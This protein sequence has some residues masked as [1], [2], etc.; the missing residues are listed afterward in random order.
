MK[1]DQDQRIVMTLDAGGTNFVFSAMQAC[2][3]IVEPITLPSHANDLP[4]C[5]KT[6]V[7]GFTQVRD[8][9][10]EKPVAI[11]FAFPGPADYASGI[12]GD[13]GNLPGL[14]RRR[15]PGA[16]AGG[17]VRPAGLSE[18]RRRPVRL[19]RGHCRLASLCER[20]AR[21]R[22]GSPKRYQN[23]FGVTL[24][25]GFGGGH[26]PTTAS[27]SSATTARPPKSGSSA[28]N[29]IGQCFVEE[30]VSIRA[31]QRVYADNAKTRHAAAARAPR[32]S[33][34]IATGNAQGDTQ[35]RPCRPS[36][37]WARASATPWPTPSRC[38]T[39]WW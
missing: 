3:E 13:L 36:T 9:L 8:S 26:R 11:S 1:I 30:D 10:R 22:R 38:S 20:K 19:R 4:A 14:S 32:K 18:Q 2:R 7:D 31:V 34:D 21:R 15:G 16:D 27:C 33:Y 29:A 24:G 35:P 6:I 28:A 12:I 17:Q 23:L 5:L 25:T 39:G 37:R